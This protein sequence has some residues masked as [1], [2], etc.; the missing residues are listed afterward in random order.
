MNEKCSSSLISCPATPWFDEVNP[1]K[2]CCSNLTGNAVVSEWHVALRGGNWEGEIMPPSDQS[3]QL[4]EKKKENLPISEL[5]MVSNHCF[6]LLWSLFAWQNVDI[7][8]QVLHVPPRLLSQ[9][10]NY[11]AWF[12]KQWLLYLSS[13]DKKNLVL[14]LA[15]T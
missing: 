4:M 15:T 5:S 2:P 12:A 11:N 6:C 8:V 9:Q 14:F 1:W 10:R 7:L 13:Q 3:F